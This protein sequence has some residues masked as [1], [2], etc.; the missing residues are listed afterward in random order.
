MEQAVKAWE[1]EQKRIKAL[2]AS[3]ATK[4]KANETVKNAKV[5]EQGGTKKKRDDAI[6]SGVEGGEIKVSPPN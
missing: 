6:S 1:L 3:G 4:T 5:K 2:K